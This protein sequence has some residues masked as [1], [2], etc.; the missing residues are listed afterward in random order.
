M[1]SISFSLT[2]AAAL[3]FCWVTPLTGQSITVRVLNAR[4]GRPLAGQNVT[5]AWT[6]TIDKT[7][8]S[9]GPE[10]TG[11]LDVAGRS[12]FTMLPGPR[13]GREPYRIAYI[14]CNN[15]S[16]VRVDD[17]VSQGIVAANLCSS[18]VSAKVKPGEIV[19]W[20]VPLHWWEPDLQ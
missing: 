4:S 14:D 9:L 2:L 20:G 8:V 12:Q 5:I 17:V 18:K 19:F 13:S 6:D 1:S 11:K 15:F 7:V 3:L 10:G 16:M